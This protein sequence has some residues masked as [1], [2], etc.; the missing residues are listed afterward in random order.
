MDYRQQYA[1]EL[2][3]LKDHLQRHVKPDEARPAWLYFNKRL[4]LSQFY[5]D[6]REENPMESLEFAMGDA[7]ASV[8][9]VVKS[10]ND[11][12]SVALIKGIKR[13]LANQSTPAKTYRF[14]NICTLSFTKEADF[15]EHGPAL[16]TEIAI[17]KPEL[18]IT[19]LQI[20]IKG[21]PFQTLDLTP[22]ILSSESSLDLYLE[23]NLGAILSLL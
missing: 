13:Y 15:I 8:V 16:A 23:Q 2:Q 17:I 1:N 11:P 14:H 3:G 6:L 4:R 21:L 18:I 12:D 9:L 19:P 5:D 20:K 7:N 10:F 22:E